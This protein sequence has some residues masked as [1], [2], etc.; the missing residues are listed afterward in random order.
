M[1]HELWIRANPRSFFIWNKRQNQLIW[2]KGDNREMSSWKMMDSVQIDGS[3]R[4]ESILIAVIKSDCSNRNCIFFW[5]GKNKNENAT[6]SRKFCRSEESSLTISK[7]SARAAGKM[8]VPEG[9]DN[10]YECSFYARIPF[11]TEASR[12]LRYETSTGT[13]FKFLMITKKN[14]IQWKML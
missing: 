3:Q 10:T 12:D 13:K 14:R 8:E 11:I 7:R 6:K 2:K 9:A 5:R 1:S 4:P